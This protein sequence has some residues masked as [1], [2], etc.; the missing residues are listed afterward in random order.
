MP[1]C[2][3]VVNDEPSVL[4]LLNDILS[5]SPRFDVVTFARNHTDPDALARLDLALIIVD[6]LPSPES[7]LPAFVLLRRILNHDKLRSVPLLILSEPHLIGLHR[8]EL[9]VHDNVHFLAKPFALDEFE[10]IVAP[11]TMGEEPP[12][13]ELPHA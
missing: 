6:P 13:A 2:I 5:P 7:E 1:K 10:A 4:A 11:L 3:A 12:N 9:E 8:G